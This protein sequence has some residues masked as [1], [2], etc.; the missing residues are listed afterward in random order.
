MQ[1]ALSTIMLMLYSVLA[2]AQDGANIPPSPTVDIIYVVIFCVLFIGSIV[3][4]FLYVWLNE[5]KK[6]QPE[7]H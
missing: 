7:G 4:F 2:V 1:K 5:R 6:K 3:G